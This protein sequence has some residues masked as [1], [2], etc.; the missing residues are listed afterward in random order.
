MLF[1]PDR[2]F[3]S[4]GRPNC[5]HERRWAAGSRHTCLL[6][7]RKSASAISQHGPEV[8]LQARTATLRLSTI[9]RSRT[10]T[11]KEQPTT[12]T[13]HVW[14]S[15]LPPPTAPTSHT[16]PHALQASGR[17]EPRWLAA[18]GQTGYNAHAKNTNNMAH[19]SDRGHRPKE[20]AQMKVR[21]R[22]RLLLAW[23]MPA[24]RIANE[25]SRCGGSR[26]AE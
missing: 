3:S 24:Q 15:H 5:S 12:A 9:G 25:S 17:L 13:L 16:M 7:G 6:L 22:L 4:A 8:C 26:L 14:T 23:R 21:R 20:N 1:A 2:V 18:L 10:H 11:A 19:T